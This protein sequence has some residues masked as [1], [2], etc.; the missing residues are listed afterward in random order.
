MRLRNQKVL[1]RTSEG[2]GVNVGMV[3]LCG[4]MS[5]PL[6]L[7]SS[8][9]RMRDKSIPFGSCLRALYDSITKA[10]TTAENS[11]A[12]RKRWYQHLQAVHDSESD[13]Q[14]SKGC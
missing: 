2:V 10:V 6:A 11:P 7:P 8:W 1:M 9:A 4:V 12:F 14:K 3:K 5:V 13:S